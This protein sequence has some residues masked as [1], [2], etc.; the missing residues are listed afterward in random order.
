MYDTL[1]NLI[2]LIGFLTFFISGMAI[3]AILFFIFNP[4]YRKEILEDWRRK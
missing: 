1:D 3:I 4:S 2:I